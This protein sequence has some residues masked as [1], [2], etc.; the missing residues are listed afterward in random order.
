M[1]DELIARL[2][3]ATGPDRELDRQIKMAHAGWLSTQG[4]S[5]EQMVAAVGGN[6]YDDPLP[7]TAS[8]DAALT[9][10][11]HEY[12]ITTL[13]GVARV[14]VNM[15]HGDDGQPFCGERRDGNVPLALCIA[16]MKMRA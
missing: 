9:L 12:E 16:A 2:E 6:L 1:M 15:N 10:V 14:T 7:Y 11:P 3:Q 8:I 4:A 5:A 13:Y